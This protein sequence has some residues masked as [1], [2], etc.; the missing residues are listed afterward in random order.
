MQW[1]RELSYEYLVDK[2]ELVEH[3][4]V[5]R[6]QKEMIVYNFDEYVN[7]KN[8]VIGR[9]EEVSNGKEEDAFKTMTCKIIDFSFAENKSNIKLDGKSCMSYNRIPMNKIM[10]NIELDVHKDIRRE[11]QCKQIELQLRKLNNEHELDKVWWI[12]SNRLYKLDKL[13]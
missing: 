5:D 10:D 1:T 12:E 3:M 11:D 8:H 9:L 7:L 6:F 13:L 2:R 4:N